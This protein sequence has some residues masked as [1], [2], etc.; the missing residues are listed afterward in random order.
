M[1][2]A[3][4]PG[5]SPMWYCRSPSG[6]AILRS[7]GVST[8]LSAFGKTSP[9]LRWLLRWRETR[10][11]IVPRSHERQAESIR[12]WPTLSRRVAGSGPPCD[13]PSAASR[14]AIRAARRRR[15]CSRRRSV[16]ASDASRDRDE[17]P[18]PAVPASSGHGRRGQARQPARAG[19][20]RRSSRTV[21]A[22]AAAATGAGAAAATGSPATDDA[23][24]GPSTTTADRRPSPRHGRCVE[25]VVGLDE[26]PGISR[27]RRAS[28][29]RP[30]AVPSSSMNPSGA[31][32]T[33]RPPT[34]TDPA[35]ERGQVDEVGVLGSDPRRWRPVRPRPRRRDPGRAAGRAVAGAGPGRRAGQPSTSAG[36]A[37]HDREPP[38]GRVRVRP[39]DDA[40]HRRDAAL[41]ERR[42]GDPGAGLADHDRVLRTDLDL[43][44]PAVA[45]LVDAR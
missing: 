35:D 22:T 26:R 23:G 27:L 42:A 7:D 32:S 14:A 44:T 28:T 33:T 29:I 11:R 20:G 34:R 37:R 8:R 43:G 16:T 24:P 18:S 2:S 15:A 17:P 41:D 36:N 6:I 31:R 13:R 1:Y 21:P 9:S 38:V 30:I 5:P 25:R 39:P 40:G 19:H 10:P 45:E 4:S 12:A 3:S